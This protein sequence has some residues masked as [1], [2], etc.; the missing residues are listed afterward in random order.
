MRTKPEYRQ[1]QSSTF[2]QSSWD[3]HIEK[4]PGKNLLIQDLLENQLLP[5]PFSLRFPRH[6][7]FSS[8][9]ACNSSS[10]IHHPISKSDDRNEMTLGRW[11]NTTMRNLS[12]RGVPP[13]PLQTKILQKKSYGFGG[14]PPPPLYG[15]SPEKCSSKSARN[16]VFCPKNTCFWSKK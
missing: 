2:P 16:G 14:Y 8:A 9:L 15:H 10:T 6:R 3:P 11:S 5:H 13:P 7:G 12:V 1:V 4:A